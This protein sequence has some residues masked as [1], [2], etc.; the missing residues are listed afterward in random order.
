M[1]LD[2]KTHNR[3][4]QAYMDMKEYKNKTGLKIFNP[5]KN[6]KDSKWINYFWLVICKGC[7]VLLQCMLCFMKHVTG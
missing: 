4:A 7:C 2:T 6:F 3:G 5:K 1:I